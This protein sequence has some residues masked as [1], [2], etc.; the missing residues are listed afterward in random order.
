MVVTLCALMHDRQCQARIDAAAIDQ[1]RASSALTVVASLLRTGQLQVLSQSIKQRR[2]SVELESVRLAVDVE[3][4][5]ADNGGVRV[6]LLRLGH[7]WHGNCRSSELEYIAARKI[8]VAGALHGFT[9]YACPRGMNILDLQEMDV[10]RFLLR[11]VP[12]SE[13][14]PLTRGKRIRHSTCQKE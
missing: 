5:S 10:S 4:H 13:V 8:E 3:R 9:Q 11:P 1:H 12:K 6:R 2:S 14:I 7:Q